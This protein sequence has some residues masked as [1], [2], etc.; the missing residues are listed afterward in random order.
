MSRERGERRGRGA[1][2]DG[3]DASVAAG[4]VEAL[5]VGAGEYVAAVAAH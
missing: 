5:V 3:D 4:V 2:V 1:A